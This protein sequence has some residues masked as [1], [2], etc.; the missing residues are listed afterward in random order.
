MLKTY[1]PD[2]KFGSTL[3][4]VKGYFRNSAEAA[5]YLCIKEQYP[6]LELVFVFANPS[7]P[8]PWAKRRKDGSRMTHAEWAEQKGFT[9]YS[10]NNTPKEWGK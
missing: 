4:E 5:K 9:Y 7:K 6:H 2:A 8:I 10:V 1:N 3:I